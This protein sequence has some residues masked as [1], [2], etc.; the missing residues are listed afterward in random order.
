MKYY[1]CPNC[2]RVITFTFTDVSSSFNV[3]CMYKP[4]PYRIVKRKIV[5]CNTQ[6]NYKGDGFLGWLRTKFTR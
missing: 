2:K 1:K 4:K 6:M 5:T 3:T